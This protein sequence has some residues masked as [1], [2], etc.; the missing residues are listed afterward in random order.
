MLLF[1]WIHDA[2]AARIAAGRALPGQWSVCF[3][4]ARSRAP[5]KKARIESAIVRPFRHRY[6]RFH[7][8]GR[9]RRD[10]RKRR[11]ATS[12]PNLT[13]P[14][15]RNRLGV[16]L[17]SKRGNTD[18]PAYAAIAR[19]RAGTNATIQFLSG[20]NRRPETPLP[21]ISPSNIRISLLSLNDSHILPTRRVI[22]A[23]SISI[24]FP[25]PENIIDFDFPVNL[26]SP[27]TAYVSFSFAVHEPSFAGPKATHQ[28]FL[29]IAPGPRPLSLQ[30]AA[31]ISHSLI[32]HSIRFP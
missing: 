29:R 20:I 18:C 16:R 26:E 23:I 28:A 14:M 27:T 31:F 6:A 8:V 5:G 21:I 22:I 24:K 13:A 2:G 11:Q 10:P 1:D 32:C 9:R 17:R 25:K 3:A 30:L 19:Q 7:R 15:A 4:C 12:L